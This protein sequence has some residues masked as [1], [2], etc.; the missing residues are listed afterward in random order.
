MKPVHTHSNTCIDFRV[1]NKDKD[2]T[3]Q[4]CDQAR[5]SKDKRIFVKD[6]TPEIGLKK[7]L[8]LEKFKNTV[9]CTY[10]IE[11]LSGKEIV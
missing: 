6:Y 7:F 5:I 3:F 9:L 11:H 8:L 2:P 4:I 10:V 1:E